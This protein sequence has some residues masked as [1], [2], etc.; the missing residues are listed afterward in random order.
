M[1]TSVGPMPEHTCGLRNGRAYRI[2]KSSGWWQLAVDE[3][4]LGAYRSLAAAE[5]ALDA[6]CGVEMARQRVEARRPK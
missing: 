5:R 1:V 2:D 4:S 3:V 6:E